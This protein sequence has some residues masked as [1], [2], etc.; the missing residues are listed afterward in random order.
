MLVFNFDEVF[1]I[2][3]ESLE[4]MVFKFI[5]KGENGLVNLL[6]FLK[7]VYVYI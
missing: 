2:G 4:N 1:I 5:R 3:K 6:Y 7:R